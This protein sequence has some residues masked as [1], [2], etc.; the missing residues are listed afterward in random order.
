ML[1]LSQYCEYRQEKACSS[2]ATMDN[3]VSTENMLPN[4]AGISKASSI[5]STG[6]LAVFKKGDVLVSNIRPYFKKI[7][8]ADFDGFCSNDVLVLK[9]KSNCN[10]EYLYFLL[11]DDRFF[12]YA[13]KTAKGTKMPRGDKASIMGYLVQG[14]SR[15]EQDH[16]VSILAP[17][18][19]KI[20]INNQLNDYLED[21]L[22]LQYHQLFDTPRQTKTIGH[23][24]D[25]GEVVGGG[26]PSKTHP[27]YYSEREI[28]WIT[29][30]DLSEG[31]NKFIQRGKQDIS[32]LGLK[33]SSARMLPTGTVLMSSRAP[34]GYLAIADNLLCTNQGFKSIIPN[35]K[36]GTGF[37]YYWLKTHMNEIRAKSTGSTFLEISAGIL[38]EIEVS[39]PNELSLKI[40]QNLCSNIFSLQR[41]LEQQNKQLQTLRDSLLPK[42]L[43]GEITVD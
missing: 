24:K 22:E 20:S 11:S 33:K 12:S 16:I 8:L 34:I 31:T 14:H 40:F 43:S 4:K 29:P 32:E 5:P 13:T 39:I 37:I 25:F 42:L 1:E 6:K 38:R 15:L 26:T 36:F 28:A 2:L 41:N 30:K 9:A 10:S 3:Y 19:R 23:V 27:E 21:F 18:E 35:E 7:W 17:L